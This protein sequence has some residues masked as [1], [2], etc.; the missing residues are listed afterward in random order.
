MNDR[1]QF[2][3]RLN[4]VPNVERRRK[5][6]KLIDRPFGTLD[7]G[8]SVAGQYG[9]GNGA[10]SGCSR[11]GVIA[12]HRMLELRCREPAAGEYARPCIENRFSAV[13][14]LPGGSCCACEKTADEG[15]G[16]MY[17]NDDF[18]DKTSARGDGGCDGAMR[19]SGRRRGAVVAAGGGGDRADGVAARHPPYAESS[20]HHARRHS[21]AGTAAAAGARRCQA[22]SGSA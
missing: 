14:A 17:E 10:A 12:H 22:A 11:V 13:G 1:S 2:L 4:A 21:R 5:K 8:H 9:T 20:T 18:P 16:G 3:P 6:K 15:I 7:F 19:R